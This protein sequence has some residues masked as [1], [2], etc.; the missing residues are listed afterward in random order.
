MK[1]YTEVNWKWN[2]SGD[3]LVETSSKTEEWN[4]P[5]A[6][7]YKGAWQPST[8]QYGI[9]GSNKNSKIGTMRRAQE[10]GVLDR[11]QTTAGKYGMGSVKVKDKGHGYFDKISHVGNRFSDE[12]KAKGQLKPLEGAESSW[13][14]DDSLKDTSLED[15]KVPKGIG[16]MME[17]A[18]LQ[19]DADELGYETSLA[20]SRQMEIDALSVE[21][22]S[23]D[24]YASDMSKISRQQG[25]GLRQSYQGQKQASA[26]GSQSG[27]AKSGSIERLREMGEDKTRGSLQ[28]IQTQKDIVREAREK[29]LGNAETLRADAVS[30]RTTAE[31]TWG[32]AQN[33]FED[34]MRK[35][36]EGLE[37]GITSLDADIWDI[38]ADD[39]AIQGAI[40][41][42]GGYGGDYWKPA[43]DTGKFKDV[44]GMISTASE[45][46]QAFKNETS[47]GGGGD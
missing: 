33:T 4:G 18:G 15:I 46:L 31:S 11:G 10:A 9:F 44:Q 2:N 39:D 20:E 24:V 40:R 6:L 22:K 32:I 13:E 7:C 47:G 14:I 23:K 16:Q 36:G 12:W 34:E 29:G 35:A 3:E 1:V 28:D 41:S 38:Q 19:R 45:Q 25:E 27:F 26:A 42:K 5:V 30:G 8:G 43:E 37:A 21:K 17:T